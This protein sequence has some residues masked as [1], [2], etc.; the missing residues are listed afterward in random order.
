MSGA[1]SARREEESFCVQAGKL[2]SYP[3]FWLLS[4]PPCLFYLVG[5]AAEYWAVRILTCTECWEAGSP[6]TE[7]DASRGF[8]IGCTVGPLVGLVSGGPIFD[9]FGGYR[10][11]SRSLL[12]C[13][14]IAF[15]A[16]FGSPF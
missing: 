1:I 10:N 3:D 5:T 11:T 13:M 2:L 8:L 9:F 16:L 12:L 7:H 6:M 4:L 15:L 14:V